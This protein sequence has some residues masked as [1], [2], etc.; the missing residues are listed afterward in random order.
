[1]RDIY[2]SISHM[3][4]MLFRA[5]WRAGSRVICA[6]SRMSPHVVFVCRACGSCALLRVVRALIAFVARRLGAKSHLL[7]VVTYHSRVS[8]T[9]FS[10]VARNVVCRLRVSH[11]VRAL[12][13]I[14]SL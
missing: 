13:L 7:R 1:M 9:L 14:V 5:R 6:L 4:R 12:W 2:L 8:R 11:A 10:H 3:S